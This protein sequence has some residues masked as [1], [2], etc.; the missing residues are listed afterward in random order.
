MRTA[1]P[2]GRVRGAAG[3]RCSARAGRRGRRFARRSRAAR[4]APCPAERRRTE[5]ATRTPRGLHPRPPHH[6]ARPGPTRR[7]RLH[8][9]AAPE[10]APAAAPDRRPARRDPL[11]HATPPRMPR[12]RGAPPSP[13]PPPVSTGW[14]SRSRRP[15]VNRGCSRPTSSRPGRSTP[16]RSHRRGSP[17]STATRSGSTGTSCR[18][19]PRRCSPRS[20]ASGAPVTDLEPVDGGV[21]PL[22]ALRAGDLAP[23]R[24]HPDAAPPA[25]DRPGRPRHSVHGRGARGRDLPAVPRLPARRCAAH[26]RVHRA[27]RVDRTSEKESRR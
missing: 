14:S 9:H 6:P 22:A 3:S 25:P 7:V 26:R 15:S 24:V 20:A 16:C 5:A 2:G 17:R 21:R 19:P 13:C 27:H 12:G 10:H 11:V 1:R 23:A 8:P 4:Q 18:A